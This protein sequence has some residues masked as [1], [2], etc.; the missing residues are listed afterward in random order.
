MDMDGWMRKESWID[1]WTNRCLGW[2]NEYGLMVG[3]IS[4]DELTNG[5]G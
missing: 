3:W 4:I 2:L 1:E 5:Y